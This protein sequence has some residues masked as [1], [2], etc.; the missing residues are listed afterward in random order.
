MVSKTMKRIGSR[1]EVWHGSCEKTSG[2]LKKKDLMKTK[3]GR[4]V[5]RKK[6]LQGKKSIKHLR[7]LGYI[8]KKGTFKLF[9]KSMVD[10]RRHKKGRHTRKRGGAAGPSSSMGL[11]FHDAML[12]TTY[13]M[14]ASSK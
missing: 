3:T 14:G 6:H 12:K 10:G 7:A 4:I 8:A 9:R 11:L 1:A 2:G 5:S 13:G